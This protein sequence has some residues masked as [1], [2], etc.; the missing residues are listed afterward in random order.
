MKSIS[1]C[2]SGR[3]VSASRGASSARSALRAGRP[4]ASRLGFG[5]PPAL[6]HRLLHRLGLLVDLLEHERLEA[7]LLGALE[8][9]GDLLRRRRF[10]LLAVD[11]D[12]DAARRD[13][14]HLA[15]RG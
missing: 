9:P 11:E 14:D 3:R 5:P 15:V 8:I 7:A 10:D 13:L 2:G 12:A 1:S 6:A 4:G